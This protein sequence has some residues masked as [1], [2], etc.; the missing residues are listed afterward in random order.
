[1]KAIICTQ[2]GSPEVLQLR[3]VAKPVPKS[4]EVLIKIS[5]TAV[6]ASDC[7][8]R[9]F[10]FGFWPPL[11]LMIGL[12]G[13]IKKPRKPIFGSVF[14]GGIETTWKDV[15]QFQAGEQVYGITQLRL[16]TY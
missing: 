5:A 8:M 3:E 15:K 14:A 6:T 2:Y 13:G 16:C 9:S 10:R 12:I 4:N 1:M 7:M 11:R